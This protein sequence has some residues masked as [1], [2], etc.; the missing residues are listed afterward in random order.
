MCTKILTYRSGKGY[1]KEFSLLYGST[2][3]GDYLLM[4]E[5][6]MKQDEDYIACNFRGG[7]RHYKRFKQLIFNTNFLDKMLLKHGSLKCVYCGKPNLVIYHWEDENKRLANMAT[8]DHFNPKS[9]GGKAYDE[10]NCVVSCYK[11]NT[12]KR[13]KMFSIRMLRYLSF[14]G[15][16][17]ELVKKLIY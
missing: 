17:K 4:K 5:E 15:N 8:C 9:N 14:Y 6:L 13:S 10:N 2:P 12:K 3:Y 7:K 1:F 11:C 16:F